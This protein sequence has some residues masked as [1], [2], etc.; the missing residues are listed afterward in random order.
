M[1]RNKRLFLSGVG[2]K[3]GTDINY[4]VLGKR[5]HDMKK[6]LVIG[7][8]LAVTLSGCGKSVQDYV[9][10]APVKQEQTVKDT[11]KES[12]QIEPTEQTEV[13]EDGFT[14][15]DVA[16]KEFYFASG[17]G[18]WCTVLYIDEDGTFEGNYHDSDM[19]DT[20]DGYP[21]GTLYYCEFEGEFTK[22]EKVNDYT[23]KFQIKDISFANKPG[24]QEIIDEI[25]YV[26]SDAYGL[27]NAKDI[28]MYLPG[29]PISE[30]P[31]AY[32][33]WVRM[34]WGYDD[35]GKPAE[36]PFYGLYNVAQ[37]EGF[38]S[39]E[40]ISSNGSSASAE[41]EPTTDTS[42]MTPYELAQQAVTEA[43]QKAQI[44]EKELE[45]E[46][47]PQTTMN[48]KA[49][50]IYIIWDDKLNYIWQ[51]MK[52]NLPE[53]QM[54]EI[55]QVQRKWISDKERKAKEAGAECE[56]GSLQPFLESITAAE[57]TE[58]RVYELLEYLK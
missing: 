34:T 8:L 3:S 12:E 38:S 14:F 29:A 13:E 30:L 4:L 28:Y 55:L 33:D 49:N 16:K 26:Y 50:E 1:L 36:L 45:T 57:L 56:G 40:D 31:E 47:L 7:L 21:N 9:K 52:E 25:L 43:E 27:E 32:I 53:D 17:A 10:D 2:Q 22:P 39:Y 48:L 6:S 58:K 44:I 20:S 42:Q 11:E 37:E 46:D 15:A 24:T 18:A 23:Y 54:K 5:E 51:L 35:E 19:G 41:D